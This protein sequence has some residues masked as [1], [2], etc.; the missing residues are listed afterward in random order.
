MECEI[1]MEKK[2]RCCSL[3]FLIVFFA[4]MQIM[5]VVLFNIPHITYASSCSKKNNFLSQIKLSGV[6]A[7]S[8]TYNFA[9]PIAT[10]EYP[11][12]NYNGN[13]NDDFKA[14]GFTI[15]ELDITLSKNPFS[16]GRNN[17]GLGFTATLDTGESIQHPESYMGNL[18]YYME[19]AYKR[20]LYGFR[21]LYVS[22]G[23]PVGNGLKV[24]IGMHNSPIGFESHNLSKNW[25]NTYSIIDSVEPGS[26]TGIALSYPIIP[27]KLKTFFQVS[28]VYQSMLPINSYPT[29]EFYISYKPLKI[30]NFH[31]GMV[32]GA[33]N[34]LIYNN[35]IIPDNLNKYFYNYMD[36]E[37]KTL[38]RLDFVL[39]YEMRSNG[40]INKSIIQNNN[41]NIN[42]AVSPNTALISTS[43]STYGRSHFSGLAFYIHHYDLLKIGRFSQ[44]VREVR[45]WDPNGMWE[46][47]STPGESFN[48]FDSTLTLGF[49]PAM[50]IFKHAQ[51]RVELEN[52]ITNHRVFGDG[53][54]VQN[55]INF[56][57][58]RTF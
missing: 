46:S 36:A 25:E 13:Y 10:S 54:R 37:Y 29:Y 56:M 58:I 15:N 40:G 8:Y 38:H 52:Q 2:Q 55:T 57:L 30:I 27:K 18:S 14:N 12:G 48:Y 49:R 43:N 22:F 17:F 39:D 20:P 41:L 24:D 7:T 11:H 34:F 19:P 50:N 53:K 35:N 28:Y 32:Y 21:N 31:E 23:I 26:L 45:V 33:E 9:D 16:D 51:F 5:S 44:T 1:K 47:A 4:V 6:F 42:E 3:K